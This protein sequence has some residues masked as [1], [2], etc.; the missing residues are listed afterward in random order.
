MTVWASYTG[1]HTDELQLLHADFLTAGLGPSCFDGAKLLCQGGCSKRLKTI[2][3][4]GIAY[5]KT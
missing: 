5:R 1:L 2:M 3:H 4:S